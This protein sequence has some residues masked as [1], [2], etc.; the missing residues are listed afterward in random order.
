M[1]FLGGA[2]IDLLI[3][4]RAAYRP[5]PTRDV[6]VAVAEVITYADYAALCERLRA[7]GFEE[8]VSESA[9]ACRWITG[10]VVVDIMPT[11]S[12]PWGEVN[13]F[14]ALAIDHFERCVVEDGITVRVAS[15]PCFIGAKLSAFEGR[16]RGDVLASH[17]VEDIVSVVDGRP[18][19][20]A[21]VD[22][23]AI[24]LRGP[25]RDLAR[26]LVE[27]HAPGD[28]AAAHL[29]GDAIS[30]ARADIVAERLLAIARR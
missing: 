23:S 1:A 20:V 4:D 6:D 26:R 22:A 18:T 15:A 28:L 5:R 14:H 17:D 24:E 30:Q 2:V 13:P 7:F 3:T 29:P 9:P 10:G 16:G 21:E 19:I 11:A 27:R 8:D 25:V 12:G